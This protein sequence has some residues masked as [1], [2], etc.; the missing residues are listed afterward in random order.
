[1]NA[2]AVAKHYG[3]LTPE[4][5]FALILAAVARGDETERQRLASAA[6]RVTFSMP[7]HA[8]MA[9]AFMHLA[10]LF[11]LELLEEVA[12]YDECYFRA[13]IA[14]EAFPGRGPCPGRDPADEGAEAGAGAAGDGGAV[15]VAPGRAGLSL[16]DRYLRL[17]LAAGFTLRTKAVGWKL[18]CTRRGIP[19]LAFWDGMPGF[20]RLR[21]ALDLTDKAALTADGF[22]RWLN[23]A[24]L[25]GR[26]AFTAV[27]LSVEGVADV[28]EALLRKCLGSCGGA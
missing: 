15:P 25:S 5:R 12:R 22:L 13:D 24:R 9:D 28:A 20:D 19:P 17:A 10:F 26:P 8:P 21:R 3:S 7:D 11:Y 4:E 18:F 2:N 6:G 16:G 23:E 27:P 14:F 1:M